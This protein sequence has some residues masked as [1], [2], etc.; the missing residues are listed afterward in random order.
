MTTTELTFGL[1]VWKAAQLIHPQVGLPIASV[2]LVYGCDK[3]IYLSIHSLYF[4]LENQNSKYSN[5]DCKYQFR[6]QAAAN[7]RNIKKIGKFA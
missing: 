4:Q 5:A 1:T 7:S 3:T 6:W 2:Q